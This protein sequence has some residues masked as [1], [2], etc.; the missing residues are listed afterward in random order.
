[1]AHGPVNRIWAVAL[2][3]TLIFKIN[4]SQYADIKQAH[5]DSLITVEI[6]EKTTRTVY[7]WDIPVEELTKDGFELKS[8][9]VYGRLSK[10]D[11]DFSA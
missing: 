2:S 7:L 10:K 1:M 4:E 9:G 11:Y 8:K 5:P 3:R 6:G